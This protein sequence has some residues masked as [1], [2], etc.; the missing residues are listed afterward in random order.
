MALPSLVMDVQAMAD[1]WVRLRASEDPE[2]YGAAAWMEMPSEVWAD[3][4]ARYPDMAEWVAHAKR[5]PDDIVAELARHPE[6]RVRATV[7]AQRR[8]DPKLRAD[9]AADPDEFVRS[10]AQRF[11]KTDDE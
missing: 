10:S 7:A 1:E 4:L 11:L 3:V 6:P 5:S 2:E 8:L 9:L